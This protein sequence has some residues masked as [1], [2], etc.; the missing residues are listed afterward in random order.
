MAG[1]VEVEFHLHGHEVA[2]VH[3]EGAEVEDFVER[4]LLAYGVDVGE[5]VYFAPL[6]VVW[7]VSE[8]LLK[9]GG[10]F[11]P[12]LAEDV[13]AGFCLL[14]GVAVVPP[15]GL[16]VLEE[17]GDSLFYGVPSEHVLE[18][19]FTQFIAEGIVEEEVEQFVIDDGGGGFA[20][21][22][23]VP[24]GE[25]LDEVFVFVAGL[26][27]QAGE[28]L[29]HLV[30]GA[31]I[32]IALDGFAVFEAPLFF[33]GEQLVD[34]QEAVIGQVVAR[35][36]VSGAFRRAIVGGDDEAGGRVYAVGILVEGEVCAFCMGRIGGQMQGVGGI[37]HEKGVDARIA[38]WDFSGA[39]PGDV[40]VGI[41]IEDVEADEV[42]AADVLL[43]FFEILAALEVVEGFEEAAVEME[44]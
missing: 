23:A 37:E 31:G 13:F 26:L 18:A 25:D 4:F 30:G 5:G 24:V 22:L 15:G 39:P 17:F 44:Q 41:G 9:L 19:F 36:V 40:V 14:G 27:Q 43:K 1:G 34:A 32:D 42:Y 6:P 11:L 7:I 28:E 33:L 3:G 20:G 2:S 21:E 38:F 35:V 8:F 10:G 12:G 16:R 29:C